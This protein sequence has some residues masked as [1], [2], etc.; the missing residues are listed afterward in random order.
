V[1][2]RLKDNTLSRPGDV[3]ILVQKRHPMAAPLIK[4]FK[5]LNIPISG[6]DRAVLH[7]SMAVQ[8]CL[9]LLQLRVS[10]YDDY[11]TACALKSPFIAMSDETIYTL[12]YKDPTKNLFENL[13]QDTNY[14]HIVDYILN[15]RNSSFD[16]LTKFLYSILNNPCPNDSISGRHALIRYLGYDCDDILDQLIDAAQIFESEDNG[17]ITSFMT[18][19]KQS[20]TSQKRESNDND[21]SRVRLITVHKSKGLQAKLV[22]LADA[23]QKPRSYNFNSDVLWLDNQNGFVWPVTQELEPQFVTELKESKRAIQFEE[24]Y[25]LLYVALTRAE[26]ELIICGYD[27]RNSQAEYLNWYDITAQSMA[28]CATISGY[29]FDQENNVI[30]FGDASQEVNKIPNIQLVQHNLTDYPHLRT[31][32]P[33]ESALKKPLRPSRILSVQP[34]AISPLVYK[35]KAQNYMRGQALHRLF[36]ILPNHEKDQQRMISDHILKRDYKDN[37]KIKESLFNEVQ[38]VFK[39]HDF[40]H[41]FSPDARTEVPLIG[42]ILLEGKPFIVSGQVDRLLVMKDRVLVVDYKTNRP[43]VMNET[44]VPE[45]YRLQML[46]YKLLLEKIYPD[47]T[48]QTALLWTAV[49]YLLP[50]SL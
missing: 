43:P 41:L 37:H 32:P 12:R 45:I 10:S 23:T 35:S 17:Q 31:I 2:E 19:I 34:S 48:I 39:H 15:L 20:T 13:T 16:T 30:S 6:P 29:L 7:E 44:D 11:N 18:W 33:Q 24:Y 9:S 40:Q 4:A 5:D 14:D 22:I 8:D 47:R 38:R 25:R 46:S 36:R 21:L 50:L 27:V 1:F 3:M 28:P 49:P 42:E 26:Q